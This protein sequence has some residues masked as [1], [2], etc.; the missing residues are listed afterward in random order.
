MALELKRIQV[1]AE[2]FM[3]HDATYYGIRIH[4]NDLLPVY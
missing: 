1:E 3:R 2:G 4:K